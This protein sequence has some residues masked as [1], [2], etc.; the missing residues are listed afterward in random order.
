MGFS[1][2]HTYTD[3]SDESDDSL[4][5]A[6]NWPTVGRWHRCPKNAQNCGGTA[7]PPSSPVLAAPS[8]T[9]HATGR[10]TRVPTNSRVL[11]LM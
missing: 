3:E 1:L 6:A 10:P 11:P 5:I 8:A 4:M 9:Q 7:V 2:I